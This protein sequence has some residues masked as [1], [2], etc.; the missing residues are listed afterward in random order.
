MEHQYIAQ[1]TAN[2]ELVSLGFKGLFSVILLAV[3]FF[4]EKD[5]KLTKKLEKE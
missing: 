1:M 2:P 4:P 5:K 3:M